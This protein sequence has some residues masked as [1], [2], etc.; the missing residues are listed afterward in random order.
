MDNRQISRK[1][2]LSL[3]I[4]LIMYVFI[5]LTLN[6][7]YM[8]GIYISTLSEIIIV[9]GCML[10]VPVAY[11]IRN[12]LKLSEIGFVKIK[13]VTV[14]ISVVLGLCAIPCASFINVLS[15]LFT[16]NTVVSGVESLFGN[17]VMFLQILML[18][19][20]CTIGPICEEILFRGYLCSRYKKIATPFAYACISGLFFGLMHLNLNQFLYATALGFV[21]SVCYT[22]TG[23]I[24]SSIIIHVIVNTLNSVALYAAYMILPESV[25]EAENSSTSYILTF[26]AF[27]FVIAAVAVFIM[28][29]CIKYVAKIE[30]HEEEIN[31]LFKKS[32]PDGDK[33]KLGELIN[34]VPFWVYVTMTVIIMI[35]LDPLFTYL[36]EAFVY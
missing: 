2:A 19:I 16:T 13:P 22:A 7:F 8:L 18:V 11:L 4:A 20:I 29:H 3:L 26:A 6:V 33:L 21:F 1:I 23:S 25:Q 14:L 35:G 17:D 27:L 10:I 5:S 31:N 32:K 28:Y 9:E 36:Y 30:G 34:N 24:Y 15:Q 12:R